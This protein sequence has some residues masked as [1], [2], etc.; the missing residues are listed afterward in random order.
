[1]IIPSFLNH[2]SVYIVSMDIDPEPDNL[3]NNAIK[4]NKAFADFCNKRLRD[5]K[6]SKE[7]LLQKFH[8]DDIALIKSVYTVFNARNVTQQTATIRMRQKPDD[9]YSQYIDHIVLQK[10]TGNKSQIVHMM[11]AAPS[12]MTDRK[13]EAGLLIERLSKQEQSVSDFIKQGK[14]SREIS[15]M[16]VI[17]F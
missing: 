15:S 17:S 9:N 8:P 5:I 3:L 2:P 4:C 16:M 6:M 14:T 10:D 7:D 12:G 11:I 1:M 13:H